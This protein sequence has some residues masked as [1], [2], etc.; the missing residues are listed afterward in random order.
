MQG[1]AL[2]GA[3][4][5][6]VLLTAG[7]GGAPRNDAGEVTASS[8]SDAFQVKVGD[9]TGDL[10]TG[11]ISDLIL[12]PCNQAHYYE[13]YSNKQMSDATFPGASAVSEQANTYCSES[14]EPWAGISSSATKYDITFFYPT[15]DTWTKANDREILCFIGSDKGDLKGS[16]KGAKK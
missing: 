5:V 11:I 3:T 4:L 16:L 10:G 2:L 7:C 1:R 12:I 8:S 14:F 9:C 15:L 6:A 13:A